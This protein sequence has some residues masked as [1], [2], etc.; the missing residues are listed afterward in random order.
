MATIKLA[1]LFV[2]TLSKP[3][4]ASIKNQAKNHPKFKAFCISIAQTYHSIDVRLKRKLLLNPSTANENTEAVRPLNDTRAVELGANFIG[5][6]IVFT[7]AV[8]TIFAELYRSSRNA[9]SQKE[10]VEDSLKMLEKGYKELL[11]EQQSL[12]NDMSENRKQGME[13]IS[14]LELKIEQLSKKHLSQSSPQ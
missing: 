1:S 12:R 3:L 7:V 5:E 6:G 4:A 9:K 2:R 8:L 13:R 11:D 10:S 14:A